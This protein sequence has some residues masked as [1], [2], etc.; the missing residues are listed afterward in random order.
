MPSFGR[1]LIIELSKGSLF[2]RK[3]GLPRDSQEPLRLSCSPSSNA[4][5]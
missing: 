1:L 3:S 2:S 5:K 4:P